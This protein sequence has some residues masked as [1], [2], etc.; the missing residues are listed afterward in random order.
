VEE[1]RAGTR[2][3]STRTVGGGRGLSGLMLVSF[4]AL[5][6]FSAFEATFALFGEHRMGLDLASIGGVFAGVGLLLV[7]VQVRVVGPAV[8]RL[9]EGGVVRAGLL[10]NAAGLLLVAAAHSWWLLVPA[11]V[12]LV[13]GQGLV[14]PTMASMVAG[15]SRADRRGGALGVQQAAGG[16]ARVLGPLAG[17]VLFEHV[18]V[19]APY[20]AGA[21]LMVLA[22]LLFTSRSRGGSGEPTAA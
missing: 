22:A 3:S 10:V 17:G 14:T 18:G 19:P 7:F 20:V 9:G 1:S 8:A 15:R 11:L 4:V 6:A 16:L 12:L 21:A 13:V 2:D 5:S